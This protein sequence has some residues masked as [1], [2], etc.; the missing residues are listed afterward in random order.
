[1][2]GRLS[3]QSCSRVRKQ[4]SVVILPIGEATVCHIS[5]CRLTPRIGFPWSE[6]RNISFNDKKFIIKPVDKKAPD[7]VFYTGRLRMSKVRLER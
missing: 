7:F 5:C 3:L 1:M 6:I 2:T 4:P